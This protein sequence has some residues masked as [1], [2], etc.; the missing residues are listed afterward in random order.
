MAE[1]KNW[2]I[3]ERGEEFENYGRGEE[4]EKKERGEELE[5]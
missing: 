4:L 3:K 5:N 2:R 1:E